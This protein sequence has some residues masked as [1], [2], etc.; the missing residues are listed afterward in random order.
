MNSIKVFIE[1]GKK[2]VFVG[3]VNWPGWCRGARDEKSA[4]QALF[5]YGPR[6]ARVLHSREIE[7]QAPTDVSDFFVTEQHVGNSTTDFGAPA[8]VLV[9]IEGRSKTWSL[10]VFKQYWGHV[11]GHSISQWSEQKAGSYAKARAAVAE[12]LRKCLSMY[13]KPIEATCPD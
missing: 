4:H 1:T 3:A 2:K 6:Y 7:F 9:L 12:T 8:I 13:S 11:G 10:S 5:D